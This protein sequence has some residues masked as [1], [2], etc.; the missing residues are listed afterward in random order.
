MSKDPAE[1]IMTELYTAVGRALS[2]WSHVEECLCAIYTRTIITDPNAPVGYAMASFWAVESFRGKLNVID[3][4]IKL[5]CH[6]KTELLA[7]WEIIYKRCRQKNANRNELAHGTVM[8]FGRPEETYFI[9]SFYKVIRSTPWESVDFFSPTF[10]VRPKN[11]LT[12]AQ[13]DHRTQGFQM[14]AIRLNKFNGRLF[15]ELKT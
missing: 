14:F 3:A 15:E 4:A 12:A 13:I 2:A 10:D 9:P 11:R 5:R 6:G 7:M 8:N 1:E